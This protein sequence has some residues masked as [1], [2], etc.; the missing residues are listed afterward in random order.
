[1]N[2]IKI[3]E[4]YAKANLFVESA[5]EVAI[6]KGSRS[7]KTETAGGVCGY[8]V[9]LSGKAHYK[10]EDRTFT[11]HRGR[12]L[13]AGPSMALEKSVAM[14]GPWQYM[15]IH[16]R[17]EGDV[18]AR[19]YLEQ[20]LFSVALCGVQT[21]KIEALARGLIYLHGQ[22]GP[23]AELKKKMLMYQFAQYLI[24]A[25][26]EPAETSDREKVEHIT[27]YIQEHMKRGLTVE[28][29]AAELFMETKAFAYLFT[30]IMGVSPKK[31]LMAATVRKAE[32][33]L[34]ESDR[35]IG[36]VAFEVGFEDPLYFSR[37]FRK[38]TGYAPSE[39][40]K[41]VGKY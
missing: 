9:P 1:M 37:V 40:R 8:L 30:K 39:F 34:I 15:L 21:K 25:S 10:F 31:Y 22:T 3:L 18:A 28:G 13:H 24:Q 41:R 6:K 16:Y 26:Q 32:E 36:E 4:C 17:V 12:V 29:L 5:Y 23:G 19:A 35:T 7:G 20:S 2:T 14:E 11:L 38:H 33:L 27:G